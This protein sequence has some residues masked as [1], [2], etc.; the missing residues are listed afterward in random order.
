[1]RKMPEKAR[2]NTSAVKSSETSMQ[3]RGLKRTEQKSVILSAKEKGLLMTLEDLPAKEKEVLRALEAASVLRRE[4][5]LGAFVLDK[6]DTLQSAQVTTNRFSERAFEVLQ[7]IK[8]LEKRELVRTGNLFVDLSIG[9]GVLGS[10]LKVGPREEDLTQKGASLAVLL[11]V[12]EGKRECSCGC[13]TPLKEEIRS[14]HPLHL[15][16]ARKIQKFMKSANKE[17]VVR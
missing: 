8:N 17:A 14:R 7:L 2:E 10:S 3:M 6:D 5:G 12:V 13:G 9:I 11:S 16:E 1:M 15:E 4:E